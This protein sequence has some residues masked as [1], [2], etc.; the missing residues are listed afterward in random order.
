M[1]VEILNKFDSVDY[2]KKNRINIADKF[3]YKTL[4]FPFEIGYVSL[5]H[6]IL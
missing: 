3:N 6:K 4:T 1:S 2:K 5:K